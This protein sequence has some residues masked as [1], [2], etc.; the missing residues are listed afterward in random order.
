MDERELWRV[1]GEPELV[2]QERL[3]EMGYPNPRGQLYYCLVL[4]EIGLADLTVKIRKEKIEAVRA[5]VAP[6]AP[7]GAPVTTTWLEVMRTS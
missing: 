3:V 2:T 7:L 6:K 4:E 5:R 1:T